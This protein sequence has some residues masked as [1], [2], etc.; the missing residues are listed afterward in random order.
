MDNLICKYCG[1]ECLHLGS[2]LWHRHKVLARDYKTEFELDYRYPLISQS[3]KEKKQKA[4]QER[5][6]FYINNL[7]KAG[8][9]YQFKKGHDGTKRTSEQSRKRIIE[10][11]E[12][13]E[14]KGQCEICRTHF[15]HLQSHYYNL[16]GLLKI[17]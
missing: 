11:L 14:L 4:F 7:K 10:Q 15:D 3:V 9:Q 6:E 1:K 8:T 17:K 12:N 13:F 16:H 2:H 5:A